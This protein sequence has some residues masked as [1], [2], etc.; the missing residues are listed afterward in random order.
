MNKHFC[1]C[2][3]SECEHNPPN[4]PEGCDPCIKKNLQNDEIPVCFWLL[5]SDNF[6]G[7]KNYKAEDFVKFYLERKGLLTKEQE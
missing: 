7:V 6:D 3:V 5:I 2:F 1:P 4:H